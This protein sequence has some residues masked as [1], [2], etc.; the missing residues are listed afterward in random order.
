MKPS[1][2]AKVV[3]S[4]A[5]KYKAVVPDGKAEVAMAGSR[6]RVA[7]IVNEES[8][9]PVHKEE[10]SFADKAGMIAFL[11]ISIVFMYFAMVPS[12]KV[13]FDH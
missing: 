12:R 7:T 3:P 8:E 6:H 9:V 2:S 5:L 1:S 4:V 11:V 10:Q 13:W